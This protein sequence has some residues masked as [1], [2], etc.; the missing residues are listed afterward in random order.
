MIVG[1]LILLSSH[2][3][4]KTVLCL[5]RGVLQIIADGSFRE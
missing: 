4:I 3:G 2:G 1:T 5:N